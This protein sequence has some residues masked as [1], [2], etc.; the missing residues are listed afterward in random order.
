MATAQT[1]TYE[2]AAAIRERAIALGSAHVRV[3]L[4]AA[5]VMDHLDGWEGFD[6]ASD[7]LNEELAER[8][9]DYADLL[10]ERAA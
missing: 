2:Q 7:E 5:G 9:S 1:F 4:A 3:R 8:W 10:R 6:C